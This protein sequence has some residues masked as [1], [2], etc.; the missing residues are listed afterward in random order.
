MP[1]SLRAA[2]AFWGLAWAFAGSAAEHTADLPVAQAPSQATAPST[3]QD[4][5]RKLAPF[6]EPSEELLGA[7]AGGK[8]YVFAGLA[9]GWTPRAL[10]YEYDPASNAWTKKKPMALPS[11]HV[12]VTELNGKIYLFGGFTAPAS[13]PPA[14][15]PIDKAW[16]YDPATDGWRAL[17]PM[18]SRRG[19]AA[20]A[21]VNGRI[22]VIGG[23]ALDPGSDEPALLPGRPHRA[24]G[25][26]EE[27][28][29]ATD[30]WRSRSPMPTPRNHHAV[31]AVNGKIYAIGGRIGGA[32]ITT[33]SNTDVVE[34][35]DPATDRWGALKARMPTPRSAVAWGVHGNRIY[36][37]GGEFQDA[38]MLA[39]FRAVEAFDPALNRWFALPQMPLPRHGLAGGVVGDELHLVSGD[40]QSAGTGAHVDVAAHDALQLDR[41]PK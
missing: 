11:H 2:I 5:W 24:V 26:V 13:G 14:W 36:V 6:P 4:P 37:A 7:A 33:A 21:A 38:R 9:P 28:D 40:V 39:A 10:V 17:A 12:A 29:P 30:R 23:A 18:P 22:Y 41:V 31:A 3:A 27:Y 35:Y 19:A 20:A 16:E 15:A 8:L 32:F 34:E 25:T 1:K